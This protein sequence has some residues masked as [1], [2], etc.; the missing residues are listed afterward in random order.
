MNI[1]LINTWRVI[2]AKGGTEK[3]FCDMANELSRR[4]H[5][6]TAICCDNKDGM[7]GFPLD[8]RVKLVNAGLIPTPFYL[9][10]FVRKIQ[11][12]SFSR[13]ERR[14]KRATLKGDILVYK[15]RN[16]L[17]NIR[18]DVIVSFQIETTHALKTLFGNS[19]PLVTMLHGKPIRYFNPAVSAAVKSSVESSDVIQVLRPEFVDE[20][21]S[22]LPNAKVEVIPNVVP[23][24]LESGKHNSSTIINVGRISPE[25]RQALLI[26]A[27]HVI[28]DEF[29]DWKV[30]LWGETCHSPKYSRKIASLIKEKKL[31]DRVLLCG[32]TN[33]V[34]SQL[35]KASIFVFP[36]Q[37]EGWGLALTEAMAMGLPSIGCKECSAVNTLIKDGHNGYLCDSTP[38]SLANAMRKLIS[39]ENIRN[40]FGVNAKLDMKAF[41]ADCVWNQWESLLYSINNAKEKEL[42]K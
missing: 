29:P 23:Q 27:F 39:D 30:E 11:S 24:F 19:V 28:K 37:H 38:A 10:K 4:G 17:N 34:P 21:L 6:V 1:T 31:E 14:K 26:E 2:D 5:N 18:T 22:V 3:V 13:L 35:E 16:V 40:L 12:F 41:A 36:S 25:K 32:T 7:P 42:K 9:S 20:V 33:D 8:D 15:L